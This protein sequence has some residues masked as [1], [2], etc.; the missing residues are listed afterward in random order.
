VSPSASVLPDHAGGVT[1]AI[2]NS[3]AT[4]LDNERR[5]ASHDR[6]QIRRRGRYG[7][8]GALGSALCPMSLTRLSLNSLANT[9]FV[10]MVLSDPLSI[11]VQYAFASVPVKG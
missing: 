7:M 9:M 2:A 10:S 6:G 4:G 11:P 1:V 5:L 8:T 3:G